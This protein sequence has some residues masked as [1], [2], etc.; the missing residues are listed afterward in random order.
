MN[1]HKPRLVQT[2]IRSAGASRCMQLEEIRQV[3][4]ETTYIS[5]LIPSILRFPTAFWRHSNES[6][7]VSMSHLALVAIHG[8]ATAISPSR[9]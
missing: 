9:N 5:S 6:C 1:E 8:C 2:G 3:R 7:K 4:A